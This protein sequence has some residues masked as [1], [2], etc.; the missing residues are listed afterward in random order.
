MLSLAE[1]TPNLAINM[2]SDCLRKAA[3]FDG[4]VFG[5]YVRDVIVPRLNDPDC[6]VQIERVSIWFRKQEDAD[7]FVK[8]MGKSFSKVNEDNFHLI[9][10]FPCRQYKFFSLYNEFVVWF[11]IIVSPKLP[12]EDFDVNQLTYRYNGKKLL[13]NFYSDTSNSIDQIKKSILNKTCTMLPAYKKRLPLLLCKD[14]HLS[15]IKT[16][17]IERGWKVLIPIT[18]ALKI[19]IPSTVDVYWLNSNLPDRTLPSSPDTN[20]STEHSL[21]NITQSEA[22]KTFDDALGSIRRLFVQVLDSK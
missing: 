8:A 16:V 3:E 14:M 22:L 15:G 6:T 11:C 17:Y 2:I 20:K 4:E 21:K 1:T 12:I 7:H 10:E 9:Y 5:G 13:A 18:N 19:V